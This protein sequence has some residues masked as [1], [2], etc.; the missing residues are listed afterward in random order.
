MLKT[1]NWL[2]GL[3]PHLRLSSRRIR[4]FHPLNYKLK[5][6]YMISQF[7]HLSLPLWLNRIKWRR[8][9]SFKTTFGFIM[10]KRPTFS[11]LLLVDRPTYVNSKFWRLK[12]KWNLLWIMKVSRKLTYS[13]RIQRSMRFQTTR[14]LDRTGF[15][16]SPL[17]RMGRAL[18]VTTF[19]VFWR[20]VTSR[21]AAKPT[22]SICCPL[23][24]KRIGPSVVSR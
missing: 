16:A 21:W 9:G 3:F 12:R 19:C 5:P 23:K 4:R 24:V 8:G 14:I 10:L 1:L 20:F 13:P 17:V 15:R 2:W 22:A 11:Q 18:L 6:S 7:G